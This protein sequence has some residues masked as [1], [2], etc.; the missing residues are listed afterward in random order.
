MREARRRDLGEVG[1]RGE[2]GVGGVEKRMDLGMVVLGLMAMIGEKGT[3]RTEREF[4]FE[5]VS[6]PDFQTGIERSVYDISYK[7]CRMC[8]LAC[9]V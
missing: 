6:P 1:W 9:T 2:T 8:L 7:W 3:S 5:C 4:Q